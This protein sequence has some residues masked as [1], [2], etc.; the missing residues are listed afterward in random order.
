[1][2]SQKQ[3]LVL[4]EKVAEHSARTQ[5]G[6]SG[7]AEVDSVPQEERDAHARSY[8][9]DDQ[10]RYRAVAATKGAF[11]SPDTELLLMRLQSPPPLG[12]AWRRRTSSAPHP[13]LR[14]W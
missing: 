8:R 6:R 13:S 2:R 11:L 7:R 12:T 10:F 1:M 5:D 14:R 9:D 4:A 3:T